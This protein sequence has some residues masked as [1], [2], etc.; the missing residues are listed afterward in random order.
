MPVRHLFGLWVAALAVR[1]A[2]LA[3]AGDLSVLAWVEDSRTYWSMADTLLERA[4]FLVEYDPGQFAPMVERTPGYVAFLA[5]VKSVLGDRVLPVLALQSAID[6]GTVLLIA[7]IAGRLGR[8]VGM[9]AGAL[10]VVWPNMIIHSSQILTDSVFLFFFTLFMWGAVRTLEQAAPARAVGAGLALGLAT[11]IRAASWPFQLVAPLFVF[12]ALTVRLRRVAP[13]A[14]LTLVFLAASLAP[15]APWLVR[16]ALEFD[17]LTLTAQGGPHLSGW[18][19]PEVIAYAKGSDRAR[20]AATL[21]REIERTYE[22]RTGRP[23][24]EESRFEINAVYA[25]GG[26]QALMDQPPSAIAAVWLKGMAA[27]LATPAALLDPRI[28]QAIESAGDG[29]GYRTALVNA[30]RSG[31]FGLRAG[32]A[33]LAAGA[34]IAGGLQAIGFALCLR[35]RPRTTAL[36]AAIVLYFLLLTGPVISPKY[37]LP[38]EP[39]LLIWTAVAIEAVWRRLTTP[40]RRVQ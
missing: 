25:E 29:A 15:A 24:S 23:L 40:S 9:I 20:E 33:L 16:N 36:G 4:A 34:L 22:A 19:A 14:G 12:G 27:N 10:A 7:S 26:L 2:Y 37:R 32:L 30:W 3:S 18:V 38:I 6:A 11:L 35:R 1:L 31:D 8:H 39:V 17:S 13:S 28:R 5:G 21:R